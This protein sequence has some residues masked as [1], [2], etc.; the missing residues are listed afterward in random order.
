MARALSA[1][2]ATGI[3]GGNA[4]PIWLIN[5]TARRKS[6]GATVAFKWS[7]AADSGLSEFTTGRI[8]QGGLKPVKF[9][10]DV[11]HGGNIADVD[12]W[13]F[14]LLNG[15][16]FWANT[17]S[18]YQ[19]E[20]RPVELRLIF[21]RVP[22][23]SW[24]NAA[25]V[26]TGYTEDLGIT[27]RRIAFQCVGSW[28][29][30]HRELP[31]ELVAGIDS[32]E[33]VKGKQG[34]PKQLIYGDYNYRAINRDGL[35][36]FPSPSGLV[37]YGLRDVCKVDLISHKEI[38]YADHELHT[39]HLGYEGGGTD[40]IR[41]YKQESVVN[42]FVSCQSQIDTT[43]DYFHGER[44]YHGQDVLQLF[45]ADEI[46]H[47]PAVD[48]AHSSIQN[49]AYCTDEEIGNFAIFKQAGSSANCLK[50][51]FR[52]KSGCSGLTWHNLILYCTRDGDDP[53]Y[54]EISMAGKASL[55]PLPI[56]TYGSNNVFAVDLSDWNFDD[57]DPPEP[58]PDPGVLSADV[59]VKLWGE[60]SG[61]SFSNI[62]L[63]HV[64]LNTPRNTLGSQGG[65]RA[66]SGDVYACVKG[67]KF[68]AWIDAPNHVNARNAGEL[69][70]NPAYIIESLLVDECHRTPANLA[71][72]ISFNS[73]A[74]LFC[75]HNDLLAFT[76]KFAFACWVYL[77]S[78]PAS[79]CPLLQKSGTIAW[80]YRWAIGSDR[81]PFVAI[82]NGTT[83]TSFTATNAVPLSTWT[84]IAV[85]YDGSAL[86][87]YLNGA[88][89]G[90]LSVAQAV[91]DGGDAFW[92][93]FNGSVYAN[94]RL[95]ELKVWA[96]SKN[97]AEI[98]ADYNSN[99]GVFGQPEQDLVLLFHFDEGQGRDLRDWA[100]SGLR[101][102]LS[103]A[104]GASFV[105][106]KVNAP[107]QLH[108]LSFDTCALARESWKF[109]GAIAET[110]N[111]RDVIKD[112]CY[113]A[114]YAYLTRADGLE[115]VVQ[116][117]PTTSLG[118]I[119]VSDA[120][121]ER[122]GKQ[123][124]LTVGRAKQQDVYNEFVLKY[125]KL[126]N[127][128]DGVKYVINPL[129]GQYSDRCS[130]LSSDGS[131][132]W[133]KCRSCYV[134]LNTVRRWIYEAKWIR[135]DATAEA[136]LKFMIARLARRP[137]TVKFETSLK[138]LADELLDNWKINVNDLPTGIRNFAHFKLIEQ[139]IDP[140]TNRLSET[141]VDVGV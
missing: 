62:Y 71:R 42:G 110:Q 15:D 22:G 48:A 82:G 80:P 79:V 129:A 68:N 91:A 61:G 83:Q 89:N 107:R 102:G 13:G 132:Y 126:G 87:H 63:H 78:A 108:E 21:G 121:M 4:V 113:E 54:C 88:P 20:N 65:R 43:Q 66:E 112:I 76:S 104:S 1:N 44:G 134:E 27:P 57:A 55:G 128:Y 46:S 77:P 37:H 19:F 2:V 84:H 36:Y 50:L 94:C 45:Y 26:F 40:S 120:L 123:T 17:L 64:T 101:F 10:C 70:Q 30:V 90:S 33:L 92:I 16:A 124:T 32:I 75:S 135:E 23:V 14:D 5:A 127:D 18:G 137:W 109:A 7:T 67:R 81:K 97:S 117:E 115:G 51:V 116:I 99:N 85:V 25:P 74:G 69:I 141:W 39:A 96:T 136:F 12:P 56:T 106:G 105:T 100:E 111:S 53:L 139:T 6:D 58:L 130:N 52:E 41:L 72:A 103:P 8:A 133:L 138:R 59:I 93:G 34:F 118:F 35:G 98:A 114:G 28:H 11:T 140:N 60:Q 9:R 29:A 86:Y 131:T 24:D 3:Q 38:L 31:K 122:G 47:V 125:R 73:V 95:D 49:P 119:S